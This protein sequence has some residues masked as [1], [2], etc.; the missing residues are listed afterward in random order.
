MTE[1]MPGEHSFAICLTILYLYSTR[2]SGFRFRVEG[3]ALNLALYVMLPT[4]FWACC[5]TLGIPLESSRVKM[6]ALH[7][8]VTV[9]FCLVR[10]LKDW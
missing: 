8:W 5:M 6:K 3:F 4:L 9:M 1:S 7:V 10:R 2:S